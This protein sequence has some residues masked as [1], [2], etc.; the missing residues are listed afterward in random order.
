LNVGVVVTELLDG[1]FVP[2]ENSLEWESYLDLYCL[3]LTRRGHKC[4]KYV[5]SIGVSTVQTY[6]HRFGHQVKRIPCYNAWLFAPKTLLRTRR[7]ALGYTTIFRQ[8]LGPAFTLNMLREARSDGIAIL[9][10]SSYYSAFF[11]PAFLA[12]R[13]IPLVV[14]YTGGVLPAQTFSRLYWKLSIIPSL[15]A[16]SAVLLGRYDSEIASLVMDLDVPR[17]KQEFFNAPIVDNDSFHPLDKRKAQQSLGFDS[18]KKNILC[19]TYIPPRSERAQ[20]LGKD[21]YLMLDIIEGAVNA[22]GAEIRVHIA[23]WGEGADDFK[24]YVD[25]R[26]MTDRV[27]MLGRVEHSKLALHYSAS[28]LVFVPYRLERLNEGS[29]TIEAFACERPVAAFKRKSADQTE[30]AGGFLVEEQPEKGGRAMLERLRL[31]GYLEEKGTE[32]SVLA[33]Q[34]TLEFAA[35]RLEEIYSKA[36]KRK[37]SGL[38]FRPIERTP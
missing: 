37:T 27:R 3:A 35:K 11:I 13:R 28:D 4:V 33:G 19:V 26:G 31:P 23:G 21:P 9:H 34:Y 10:Y 36:V 17:S 7:Y 32:G 2:W 38:E 30:Q 20:F 15:R 14:Q 12:A 22:G 29:V 1:R 5:P 16:S 6:R 25:E 18:T 24:D 8:A